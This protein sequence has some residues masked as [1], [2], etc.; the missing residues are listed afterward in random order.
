MKLRRGPKTRS[1]EHIALELD[2]LEIP[3]ARLTRVRGVE[4]RY[5]FEISPTPFSP[6]YKCLLVIRRT[7]WPSMFVISPDLVASNNGKRP[8]HIYGYKGVQTE[9][10]L[11]WPKQREWNREMRFI[12]TYIPWT[13]E[14]LW[15]YEYWRSTGKWVGGGAHPSRS[16]K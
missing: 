9:L 4:L 8:P 1:L 5:C 16:K 10:C 12:E 15:Y 3:G 11:W 2:A 13:A 14:W 7:G 6:L